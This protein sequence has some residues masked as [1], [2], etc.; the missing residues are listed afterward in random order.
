VLLDALR[1]LVKNGTYAKVMN[2][3]GLSAN[4]L[5]KPGVNLAPREG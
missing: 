2:K 4:I 1:T 3:W 5:T